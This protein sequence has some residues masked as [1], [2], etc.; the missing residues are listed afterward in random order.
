MNAETILNATIG[1]LA[2]RGR[3]FGGFEYAGKCCVLGAM[4]V[5]AGADPDVWLALQEM[6]EVEM[7]SGDRELVAAARFLAAVV[8]PEYAGADLEKVCVH[9]GRWHD[10]NRWRADE[11]PKTSVVFEALTKAA[12]FA[13][14]AVART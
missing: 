1:V 6:P 13:E 10:G 11:A 2:R 3:C 14:Q 5:A 4:A 9:V 7:A 8:A 12:H